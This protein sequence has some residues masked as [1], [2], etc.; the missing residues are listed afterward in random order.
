MPGQGDGV[1][2]GS[3]S[4]LQLALRTSSRELGRLHNAL[5]DAR[6]QGLDGQAEAVTQ[7]LREENRRQR[8]LAEQ[9]RARDG[10]NTKPKRCRHISVSRDHGII[11]VK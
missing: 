6:A 4:T 9:V 1:G 8:K 2:D 11:N 7:Q 5:Q 3:G 10:H